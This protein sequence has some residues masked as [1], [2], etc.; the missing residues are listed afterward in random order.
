MTEDTPHINN[1]Q[2][3]ID[4]FKS[5]GKLLFFVL[6]MPFILSYIFA[7]Y[8]AVKFLILLKRLPELYILP[9]LLYLATV[10]GLIPEKFSAILTLLI[11]CIFTYLISPKLMKTFFGDFCRLWWVR[12][13]SVALTM[14][15]VYFWTMGMPVTIVSLLTLSS[16]PLGVVMLSKSNIVQ[17]K[18]PVPVCT[19]AILPRDD[20]EETIEEIIREY[21]GESNDLW[22]VRKITRFTPV[23]AS[24]LLFSVI[25]LLLGLLID[26]FLSSTYLFVILISVWWLNDLYYGMRNK[27]LF[28][29]ESLNKA[30]RGRHSP[31]LEITSSILSLGIN[32]E[33]FEK[34]P[35]IYKDCFSVVFKQFGGYI[36]LLI[37]ILG[38]ALWTT[39]AIGRFVYSVTT[40]VL[41][42]F[43]ILRFINDSVIVLALI[44]QFYFLYCLIKRFPHFLKV[45]S[46]KRFS[47]GEDIPRLP[48][49]GLYIFLVNSVLIGFLLCY[50][51]LMI[52]IYT[53]YLYTPAPPPI[54]MMV[55]V[56][57]ILILSAF[58]EVY[59]I[60]S[61]IKS[62]KQR[63]TDLNDLYKDNKRIPLASAIQFFS[64]VLYAIFIYL[65]L[66]CL[67]SIVCNHG[68]V[69]ECNPADIFSELL[70]LIPAIFSLF[71]LIILCFYVEELSLKIRKDSKRSVKCMVPYFLMGVMGFVVCLV[72]NVSFYLGIFA[73]LVSVITFIF[74][75]VYKHFKKSKN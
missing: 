48:P 56:I 30:V 50:G 73:V 37:N 39:F 64:Y 21:K 35:K 8:F 59:L 20:A 4:G 17:Q 13:I 66:S 75:V 1:H 31:E 71:C 36:S 5:K 54:V 24:G 28:K 33:N 41:S 47:I 51:P 44:F 32:V 25:C 60:Y 46:G 70:R 26:V 15:Y 65:S 53:K 58:F 27:S 12:I 18:G 57:T 49:G 45:W 67:F 34:S 68:F 61:T 63:E 72:C 22:M 55:C 6:T 40:F 9:L 11:Y 42:L 10:S 69:L 74:V 14:V 43:G 3:L 2:G 19:S 7:E 23:Y 29:F 38:V 62:R 16:I 52:F